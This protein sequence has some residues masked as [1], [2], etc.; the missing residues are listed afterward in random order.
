MDEQRRLPFKSIDKS[1]A[2]L[3]VAEQIRAAI[4]DGTLGAAD[5]LPSERQLAA[6]FAVSRTTVREA[7]RQLQAQGLLAARG[8]T[9]PM[10]TA[11]PEAAVARFR[12]ALTHVVRLRNVELTDLVEL[13]VAVEGAALERC[14]ATPVAEHLEEARAALARMAELRISSSEFYEA[15]IDFH[16]AL[17]AAS[18]NQALVLVMLAVKDS[19]RLHLDR[20]VPTRSHAKLHAKVMAEHR[21]LLHAIEHGDAKAGLALLK[22]HLEFYRT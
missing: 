8:R 21:G 13:R 6:Q 20:T 12:E 14:V 19:I 18:G 1:A 5:D 2:Y 10:G 7:L 16:V 22:T 3:Q 17:V 9:S 11:G 15:D 4:L